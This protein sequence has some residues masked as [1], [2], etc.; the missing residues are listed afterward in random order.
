M[1]AHISSAPGKTILFGEHAVVYG[2]PAIAIPVNARQAKVKIFPAIRLKPEEIRFS[3]PQIDI[4]QYYSD[5]EPNH[6]FRIAV[7]GVKSFLKIDQYPACKIQIESTIPISSGLGSSAAI[8]VALVKGLMEFV[9]YHPSPSEISN[10]AYQVEIIFHGNPSGID[11]TVISFNKPIFFQKEKPLQ[12]I[13]TKNDF[14][15]VIADSGIKGN[16]KAA[17]AGVRERWKADPEKY[18]DIFKKIGLIT[19]EAKL[20]IEKGDHEKLG[21]LM[22]SNQEY[23]Q[24]IGV[25]HPVLERMINI[26]LANHAYGAKLCG[27]GLGGNIIALVEPDRANFI[28]NLLLKS[29]A[30]Q[31]IL[32]TLIKG[33]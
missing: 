28:S 18:N 29:G 27:S 17:V 6:P 20:A 10:L 24:L 22:I 8:S 3:A 9:G 11:N 33:S 31:T 4:E 25:S 16:T 19:T 1:P 30:K 15:I 21:K 5:F 12:F 23:L 13:R 32:V 26:A 2:F 7:E 14:T